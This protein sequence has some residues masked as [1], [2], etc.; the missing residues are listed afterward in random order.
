MLAN[1]RILGVF[2]VRINRTFVRDAH[3]RG[4][5]FKVV[6]FNLEVLGH[7]YTDLLASDQYIIEKNVKTF[8]CSSLGQKPS[9]SSCLRGTGKIKCL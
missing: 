5:I 8:F 7:L 3:F 9:W 1:L 6:I 2:G 4:L